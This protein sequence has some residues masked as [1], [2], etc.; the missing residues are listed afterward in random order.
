MIKNIIFDIGKV[1][2]DYDWARYLKSYGFDEEKEQTIAYALFASGTW[3]ELDRGAIPIPE[4]EELFVAHAPQYRDDILRVFR[5]SGGTIQRLDYAI[6]WITSLKE[7][8]YHV[9]YL[10]NYSEFMID[11]TRS[12]LDFLPHTDGGVFSCDVRLIKP[13]PA[14][15]RALLEKYPSI[16]PEESVFLDDVEKNVQGAQAIGIHGIV[17]QNYE[18]AKA[19]LELLLKQN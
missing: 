12:A 5:N 1:L 8:G 13:E 9:Y 6:P 14:I 7:R 16:I 3:N 11:A 15:Y 2:V 17:F 10:S 18:Q 19:E 4:L